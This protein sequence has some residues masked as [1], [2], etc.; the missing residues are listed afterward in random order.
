M[1]S[2]VVLS[3]GSMCGPITIKADAPEI[4]AKLYC[5]SC[6]A[7]DASEGRIWVWNEKDYHSEPS[8]RPDPIEYNFKDLLSMR[9]AGE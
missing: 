9:A 2:F 7:Q 6:R 1:V 8:G 4:A 5:E 3:A